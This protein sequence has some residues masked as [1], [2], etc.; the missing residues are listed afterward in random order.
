MTHHNRNTNAVRRIW[1]RFSLTGALPVLLSYIWST[2]AVLTVSLALIWLG[3]RLPSDRH[4]AD[5]LVQQQHYVC[6]ADE[7][8][9]IRQCSV[10][11]S[12][13]VPRSMPRLPSGSTPKP[14]PP[15]SDVSPP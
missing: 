1:R 8:G 7:D 5:V 13:H 11:V 14:I 4:S 12:Q 3:S 9:T 6:T 15:S 10:R 2:C